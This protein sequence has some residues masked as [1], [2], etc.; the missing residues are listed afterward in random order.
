[1]NGPHRQAGKASAAHPKKVM[2]HTQKSLSAVHENS[3]RY[4][5]F[6]SHPD[7]TVGFGISPNRPEGSR[8]I[9][10]VGN[11]TLPRRTYSVALK[12]SIVT[13][14]TQGILSQKTSVSCTE[15]VRNKKH[16]HTGPEAERKLNRIRAG[17]NQYQAG[18]PIGSGMVPDQSQA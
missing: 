7:Y 2:Q 16:R 11:C 14:F 17:S 4:A 15:I 10:P 8:T 18:S 3:K 9:P 12:Y 13:D 6:F 1:M 5:Q